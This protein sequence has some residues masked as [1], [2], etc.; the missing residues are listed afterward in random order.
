MIDND[1]L[2]SDAQCHV[3][4]LRGFYTNF[5]A[6]IIIN[7]LLI[8]INLVS[9]PHLLWF[10]WVSLFWGIGIAYQAAHTFVPFKK[11]GRQWEKKKINEYIE[12][13]KD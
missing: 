3:S 13:H 12:K 8:I 5:V 10:Y 4:A 2:R 11:L 7:I 6:Y 1:Q 9:T